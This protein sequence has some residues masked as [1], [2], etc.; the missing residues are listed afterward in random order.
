MNGSTYYDFTLDFSQNTKI[1]KMHFSLN[2]G[3]KRMLFSSKTAESTWVLWALQPRTAE[4]VPSTW[5]NV[6][7]AGRCLNLGTD[8]HSCFHEPGILLAENF[9]MGH[10][11]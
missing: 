11:Y 7:G 10:L 4:K 8:T 9:E 3:P 2:E 6:K 1:T 5:E